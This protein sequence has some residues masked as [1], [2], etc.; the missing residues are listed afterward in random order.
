MEFHL[1]F[2]DFIEENRELLFSDS[3]KIIWFPF[4]SFSNERKVILISRK[5]IAGFCFSHCGFVS[6]QGQRSAKENRK[7]QKRA[8]VFCAC[9]I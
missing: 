2:T 1:V 5:C 4:I 9:Q 6:S 8:L 3:L 7:I